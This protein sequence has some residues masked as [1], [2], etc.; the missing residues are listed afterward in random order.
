MHVR[1]AGFLFV[2]TLALPTTASAQAVSGIAG[3]VRDTSGGGIAGRDRRGR[4]PGAHREDA[5]RR[6]RRRRPL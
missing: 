4:E 6:Q 1:L 5:K 3:V 2:A